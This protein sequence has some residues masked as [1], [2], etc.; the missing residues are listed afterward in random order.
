[1]DARQRT[2]L[3]LAEVFDYFKTAERLKA[4]MQNQRNPFTGR[5]RREDDPGLPGH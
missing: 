2:P 3:Q 4:A 5:I 1:M